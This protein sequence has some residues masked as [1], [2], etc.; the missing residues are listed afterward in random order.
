MFTNSKKILSLT[1]N[2]IFWEDF[3]CLD[4]SQCMLNKTILQV[5]AIYLDSG[6]SRCPDK[7]LALGTKVLQSY[8]YVMLTLKF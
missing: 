2:W 3:T 5:A 6:I 1:S 8:N 7:C 4:V